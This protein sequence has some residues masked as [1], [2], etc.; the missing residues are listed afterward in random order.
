MTKRF[1]SELVA[2][3]AID[4]V[5][6]LAERAMAHKKDGNPFLNVTLSDRSGQVKGVMWDQVER[7]VA[8]VAEGDFV[9]VRAQVGEY[10]GSLQLVVKDMVRVP[11]DQVDAGDFLAATTPAPS[12]ISPWVKVGPSSTTSTRFPLITPGSSTLIGDAPSM[13]TAVGFTFS[14]LSLTT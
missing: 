12:F 4:E 6:L 9:H 7:I 2:G 1:V 11:A 3:S 8:A 14:I 10:R 13:T 5:F